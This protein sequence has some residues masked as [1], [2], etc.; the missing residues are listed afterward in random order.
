MNVGGFGV[1]NWILVIKPLH[2]ALL[3][4]SLDKVEN[5][6]LSN[7]P[8]TEWTIWVKLLRKLLK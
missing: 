6:F 8:K 5:Y 1:L 3:C 4:D 2:N 7:N